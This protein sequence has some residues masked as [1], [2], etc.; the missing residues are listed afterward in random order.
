V[1][2]DEPASTLRVLVVSEDP[3]I[4]EEAE[5]GFPTGVEI[6]FASDAREAF[7]K[8][9]ARVPDVL[10]VDI[11]TGSAGGFS[12]ATEMNQRARMRDVPILMLL[13]RTQ[14]AWLANQA[15]AARHR[16]KPLETPDLV[17]DVLELAAS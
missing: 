14:D 16:V 12:L 4:R 7:R 13:E 10:V 8:L 5:F 11:Q 1:S 6:D 17:A 3:L 2:P 15:G 9:E